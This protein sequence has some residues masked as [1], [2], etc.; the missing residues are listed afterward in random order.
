MSTETSATA[1][2]IPPPFD[3]E[4]AAMLALVNLH[5]PSSLS[6]EAIT[7]LRAAGDALPTPALDDFA[8][9]GRF[10]VEE[11]TVPGP[12]GA[13]D[14]CLLIAR[15][16]AATTARPVVYFT[17]GGGMV[18]GN[19]RLGVEEV[20]DWAEEFELVVVSVEYR[21]A[22]ENPHPA[23][24][25]DCWAGLRWTFENAAGIGADP[26]RVLLAGVS[27]G[28]GLAAALGL[29]ARDRGG[30]APIGQLL[31]SPMLDDRNDTPSAVQMAGIG[32]WDRTSNATGWG[33]LLGDAAGGPD[34]SPYAAPARARD[35][36]G[37]APAFVDVG[38]AETFRD[39][40][41]AYASRIWQAGGSAELHVWPG[42]FHG[43]DG[44][45]PHAML[46]RDARAARVRWLRRILGT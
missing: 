16:A 10:L 6:G 43:F 11:R 2:A 20:L 29:L 42:G 45:V 9:E 25:E 27:A 41:L 37:L 7:A 8:R 12:E 4:L 19:N 17:H 36:A 32:I 30:P 22:P 13:P 18:I 35:L 26:S 23:P 14:V 46:S 24:I 3:P 21:L 39:E 1:P 15:P 34:V 5:V 40:S 44:L 38:S 31:L 33:A 28:G